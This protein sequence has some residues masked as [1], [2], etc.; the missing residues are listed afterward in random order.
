[1]VKAAAQLATVRRQAV[2]LNRIIESMNTGFAPLSFLGQL[3][4]RYVLDVS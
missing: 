3:V 1:M 2:E 4:R